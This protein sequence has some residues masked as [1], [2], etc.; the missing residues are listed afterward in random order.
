M[1]RAGERKFVRPILYPL[2]TSDY[3]SLY[4]VQSELR[5]KSCEEISCTST[6]YVD[7]KA[8]LTTRFGC[9]LISNA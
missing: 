2:R 5:R 6:P 4:I 1:I 8:R 9:H 7:A 3:R